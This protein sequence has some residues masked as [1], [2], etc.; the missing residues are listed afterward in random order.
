MISW[1]ISFWPSPEISLLPH[2]PNDNG[3]EEVSFSDT[4][5][6]ARCPDFPL[7]AKPVAPARYLRVFLRLPF[8][9]CVVILTQTVA[10]TYRDTA[11]THRQPCGRVD[12]QE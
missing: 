4:P 3:A 7:L 5:L 8:P 11:D 2:I 12:R 9:L 1:S 10:E 6:H